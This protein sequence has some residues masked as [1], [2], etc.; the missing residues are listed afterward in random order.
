M[1]I[2]PERWRWKTRQSTIGEEDGEQPGH[3]GEAP[4]DDADQGEVVG[5]RQGLA[6]RRPRR[7]L[8]GGRDEAGERQHRHEAGEGEPELRASADTRCVPRAAWAMPMQPCTQVT[9][10]SAVCLIAGSPQI[11]QSTLRIALAIAVEVLDAR[12]DEMIDQEI[13]DEQAEHDLHGLVARQCARSAGAPAA[14]G[15]ARYARVKAP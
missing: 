12:P 5:A 8:A 11:R 9:R 13:G 10:T 2:W 3:D 6:D 1:V 15:R 14:S 7:D 4:I